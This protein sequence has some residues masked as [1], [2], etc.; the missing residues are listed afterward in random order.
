[1][2]PA[3]ASSSLKMSHKQVLDAISKKGYAGY[4]LWSWNDGAFD[5]KPYIGND[6]INFEAEYPD[7][8]R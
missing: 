3:T 8:V 6:F 1:M 4:M 2:M 5:C 7:V